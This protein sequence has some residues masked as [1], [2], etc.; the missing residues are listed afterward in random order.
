MKKTPARF[1]LAIAITLFLV[2]SC[3]GLA[4]AYLYYEAA[5]A[6]HIMRE[7]GDVKLGDNEA[8]VLPILQ[9]YGTWQRFLEPY[10]YADKTDYEYMVDTGPSG[11]YYYYVDPLTPACSI[12]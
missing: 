8:Q 9:R 2:L 4:R 6:E 5:R 7:L 1:R 11:I 10:T 3:Y 12:A